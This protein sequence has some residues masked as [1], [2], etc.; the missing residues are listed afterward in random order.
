MSARRT[1]RWSGQRPACRTG[2]HPCGLPIP[3]R[4]TVQPPP[5]VQPTPRPVPSSVA[6]HASATTSSAGSSLT[7]G[8]THSKRGL[9][10]LSGPRAMSARSGPAVAQA[11]GSVAVVQLGGAGRAVAS[12][13]SARVRATRQPSFGA[14]AASRGRPRWGAGP[15]RRLA[16]AG[17]STAYTVCYLR[18]GLRF[19]RHSRRTTA[20]P[21]DGAGRRAPVACL[22]HGS[23]PG[24]R[25]RGSR[26]TGVVD[27]RSALRRPLARTASAAVWS[28]PCLRSLAATMSR[29]Y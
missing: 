18:Y 22:S 29:T 10:R 28:F 4:F 15:K 3:S 23:S 20:T 27:R 12:N 13:V 21:I 17:H 19:E 9:R 14:A 25:R 7:H 16:A 11:A 24:R 26:Q 8:S 6:A 1:W 2:F 5:D